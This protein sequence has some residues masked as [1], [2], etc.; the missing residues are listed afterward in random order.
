VIATITIPIV[1]AVIARSMKAQSDAFIRALEKRDDDHKDYSRKLNET[2][3]RLVV[4]LTTLELK[5]DGLG[6]HDPPE[7]A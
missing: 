6:R 2:L 5:V 7:G 1:V 3:E 4:R